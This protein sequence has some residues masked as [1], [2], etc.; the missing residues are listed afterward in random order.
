[1]ANR[2]VGASLAFVTSRTSFTQA[3]VDVTETHSTRILIQ[4]IQ[5]GDQQARELLYERCLLPVLFLVRINLGRKLRSKV[6]SWDLAQEALLRSLAD[7]DKFRYESSGAFRRFLSVKVEQVI[8]DHADYWS[9]AKRN[10]SREETAEDSDSYRSVEHLVDHRN[11]NSPSQQLRLSEE[12]SQLA[13][14]MDLLAEQSVDDWEMIVA[15][16]L[17][18]SSTKEVA[19]AMN[20]SAD[21]VRMRSKRAMVRLA[22]IFRRLEHRIIKH[23][24]E[25]RDEFSR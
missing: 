12:L 11:P 19:E 2:P 23:E 22:G 13:E 4:R 21:T 9:A 20:L 25:E 3:T 15:I 14:A 17:V 6:E 10:P 1:M 16:Q 24:D 7:L 5:G 18:G 8:R